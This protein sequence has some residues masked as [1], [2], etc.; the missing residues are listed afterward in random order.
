LGVVTGG[1]SGCGTVVEAGVAAAEPRRN[2]WLRS[3]PATAAHARS[4]TDS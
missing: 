2:D 1:G 3:S 4:A